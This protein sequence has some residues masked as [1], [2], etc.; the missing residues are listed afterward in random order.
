M[1]VD[2][3]PPD[4]KVTFDV[5]PD[6]T[7]LATYLWKTYRFLMS[8]G[9]LVNVSATR[10]DSDL[11]SAVLAYTGIE[12][13]AGVVTLTPPAPEPEVKKPPVKPPVKKPT[14][15]AGTRLPTVS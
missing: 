9:T 1:T 4:R 5:Q 10:D 2:K 13:I 7:L 6:G 12:R 3:T 11:R 15:R 8:D 14:K